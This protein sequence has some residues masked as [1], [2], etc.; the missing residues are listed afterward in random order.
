MTDQ[1]LIDTFCEIL[2]EEYDNFCGLDDAQYS[3][4]YDTLYYKFCDVAKTIPQK[5]L[6]ASNKY[7]ILERIK[8]GSKLRKEGI[9]YS[10]RDVD[11]FGRSDQ[12]SQHITQNDNRRSRN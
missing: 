6:L 11:G 12:T 2:K 1:Q 8:Y 3:K 4:I 7:R 5:Q 9:I 10:Q